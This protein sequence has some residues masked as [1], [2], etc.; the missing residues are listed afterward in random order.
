MSIWS[1]LIEANLYLVLFYV[2][3][4]IVLKGDTFFRFNRW[5][6]LFT[7]VFSLCVPF[8]KMEDLASESLQEVSSG[9][10]ILFDTLVSYKA[11]Q[12]SWYDIRMMSIGELLS[13]VYFGGLFIS[14]YF[15]LRGV[16]KLVKLIQSSDVIQCDGYYR[17]RLDGSGESAFVFCN[18]LFC[19]DDTDSH[20]LEHELVHIRQRHYLDL[21]FAQFLCV[22]LWFNPVIYFYSR[23]LRA[24]HE[25][26]ADDSVS[27]KSNLSS[28]AET[29]IN[30][31]FSGSS[32]NFINPFN[33]NLKERLIML[34]KKRTSK[35]A[36][37]KYSLALPLGLSLIF[38][39]SSAFVVKSNLIDISGR[40]EAQAA[41]SL[42]GVAGGAFDRINGFS[43][44]EKAKWLKLFSSADNIDNTS[45]N[46][47][48]VSTKPDPSTLKGKLVRDRYSV[49]LA[50]AGQ[51]MVADSMGIEHA[52]IVSSDGLQMSAKTLN[53]LDASKIQSI[54]ILKGDAAVE[55]Y[56]E[57][58]RRGAVEV[59]L[60]GDVAT[61]V[62]YPAKIGKATSISSK[63]SVKSNPV[64]DFMNSK[65]VPPLIL[66]DG[67]EINKEEMI[68]L[69]SAD[70]ESV[71]VLKDD[72]AKVEYEKRGA[73]GVVLIVTKHG[74]KTGE[75]GSA[76]MFKSAE[77][78]VILN[79]AGGTF[80]L[81][82]LDGQEISEADM[83]ALEP[84]S[85]HSINILKDVAA[86]EKYGTKGK[87]GVIEIESK[88][89][90]QNK[91]SSTSGK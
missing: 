2:F 70:I 52:Y 22:L 88:A 91:S 76:S 77:G 14:L 24:V 53:A 50:A 44:L 72:N 6:L 61:V 32:M 21:F 80:P 82:L 10:L 55:K 54:N 41:R 62:G 68:Q 89:A 63:I 31:V 74:N 64:F 59:T 60:K 25:Y 34:T 8:L 42:A 65:G 73:N 49:P 7:M 47:D 87:A 15:S 83:K 13:V 18:Y 90:K 16:F 17:V 12:T 86:T 26:L 1:Y 4:A 19:A 43:A 27:A 58:A 38:I 11:P 20:I 23:S 66:L 35:W 71:S 67:R 78:S 51:S 57:K 5:Y 39:S 29:M 48:V 69:N 84:E 37:A 45:S 28:Y 40:V 81:I 85:I 56:G 30:N 33:T 36:M 3:Y 75:K 46:N 9:T 79:K